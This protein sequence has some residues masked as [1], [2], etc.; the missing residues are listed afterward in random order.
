MRVRSVALSMLLG[1]L[2]VACGDPPP[3]LPPAPDGPG[4]GFVFP[5]GDS[6]E[7]L[8]RLSPCD[9][10]PPV[11]LAV[12]ALTGGHTFEN[13]I[14]DC[15]RLALRTGAGSLAYGPLTGVF[16]LD[17]AMALQDDTEFGSGPVVVATIFNWDARAALGEYLPLN[18]RG[19]WSCLWLRRDSTTWQGAIR[20]TDVPCDS[21][22]APPPGAWVLAVQR[23]NPGGDLP[24][25]ARWG[26]AT[27]STHYIGIKCGTAWCSVGQAGFKP[28][29][30]SVGLEPGWYDE[31][32][33]AVEQGG[34]LVPGPWAVIYPS[35][36]LIA[37]RAVT[38]TARLRVIFESPLHV[39]TIEVIGADSAAVSPYGRK[40]NLE[41]EGGVGTSDILLQLADANRVWFRNKTTT[42][43]VVTPHYMPA[44][45]HAAPGTV[46]W[47]WHATDETG[48]ISCKSGCCD[49]QEI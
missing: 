43:T 23:A 11:Q 33:I 3:I 27:D 10:I 20:G 13:E 26:W 30:S 8:I 40:F 19:Y 18:I 9:S 46:R 4:A 15:Q 16:P 48:W 42:S 36:S 34:V 31:Q 28:V 17:A 22:N 35:D 5:P 2:A 39:A 24:P 12:L 29:A 32:H 14:H 37:L 41:F 6:T 45:R 38:D 7:R 44:E 21:A 49:S 1:S 47:R 25:T